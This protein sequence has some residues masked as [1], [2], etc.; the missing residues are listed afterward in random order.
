MSITTD[1]TITATGDPITMSDLRAFVGAATDIPGSAPLV[2]K[3]GAYKGYDGY[4]VVKLTVNNEPA[5][6]TDSEATA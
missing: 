2:V 5:A 1:V 6:D 3:T 4:L